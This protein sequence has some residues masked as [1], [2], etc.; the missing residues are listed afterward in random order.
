MTALPLRYG[1]L[2]KRTSVVLCCVAYAI[3][4]ACACGAG[5]LCTGRHPLAVAALADITATATVFLFSVILDNS[6]I[7]DPYWS[8]AP[9]CIVVYFLCQSPG[10][11]SLRHLLLLLLVAGWAARLTWNWLLR[12]RGLG[13][14]DWRYSDFRSSPVYWLVSF[15]GFH[16]FP[17]IAV[18]AG[19]LPLVPALLSPL[20][21]PGLLDAIALL[22][23][24]GG[25]LIETKADRDLRIFRRRH[26]SP[27]ELLTSGIWSWCRHPNYLGEVT[28]W[29]G[30]ALFG[31]SANPAWWW[32]VAGA[33]LITALFLFI[34]APMMDKHML[35]RYPGYHERMKQLPGILPLGLFR[36]TGIQPH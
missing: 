26:Q 31:I 6:S 11:P 28:F 36:R 9:A 12:W 15:A 3:T 23:T 17:T 19:C 13:D 1:A 33:V 25:I 22:V 35:S 27:R 10:F 32:T 20:R 7:Y 18:F 30:I 24:A 5:L 16:V 21:S 29:W 14:E 2:S 34:S 8:V 4:A